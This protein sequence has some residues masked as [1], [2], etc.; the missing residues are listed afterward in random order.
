MDVKPIKTDADHAEA[1]RE[2]ERLW[3]APEGTEAGDRLDVLLT[4]VDA[5]EDRRWPVE[6]GDPVE[7]IKSAM[8]LNGRSQNELASVLGSASR[9]SEVLNRRRALTLPMI[10]ALSEEWRIPAALLVQPYERAKRAS[11]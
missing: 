10:R 8:S 11:Q 6:S 7:V 1:V 5:Y 2:V 4:L 3:G 9:A